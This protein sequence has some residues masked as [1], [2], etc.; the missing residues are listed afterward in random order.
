MGYLTK[1]DLSLFKSTEAEHKEAYEY[2]EAHQ[3]DG[4]AVVDAFMG[5]MDEAKW[6]DHEADVRKFSKKFPKVVFQLQ[7][8]GEEQGDTWIKYFRNG[9]MQTCPAVI[10]FAGFDQTKLK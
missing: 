7:G 9:K 5:R 4:D 6:Y 3:E 10:T 2:F 1:Y 8:D